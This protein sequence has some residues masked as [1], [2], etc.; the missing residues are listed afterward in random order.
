MY[1]E[2]T[3]RQN[4]RYKNWLK[5]LEGRGIKKTGEAI[6]SG[7]KFLDEMLRLFP[8]HL[9]GIIVS[10]SCP[11][12]EKEKQLCGS[13]PPVYFLPDDLFGSLDIYG[14][15]SPLLIIKAEKLPVWNE[16]I[17]TGLT[18][19][20]PFQNPINL[21]TTIRSA[22]ALGARVVV[23]K[24]AANIY[25]PKTLRAAGPGFFKTEMFQGPCL[26]ELAGYEDLPIY[27]LSPRG[28]NLFD[29]VF[30][31]SIGLV[32]GP[33]GPGLDEFWPVSKRLSIPMQPGIESLNAAA[34]VDMAMGCLFSAWSREN[35]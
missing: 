30:P 14:T 16:K 22:A 9:L 15:F 12:G 8:G 21:G 32:A 5:A 17:E 10:E 34:S 1:F 11:L 24:E 4:Q 3:S 2:I 33:E 35:I 27:A 7:R 20:L 18:L 28:A 6:L 25:H 29:F 19:F 13:F 26:A 31:D 23:L